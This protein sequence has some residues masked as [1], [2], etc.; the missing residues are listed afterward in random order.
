MKVA[1]KKPV[2]SWELANPAK[3]QEVGEPALL[4]YSC[5][6]TLSKQMMAV[7]SQVV[8]KHM[9]NGKIMGGPDLVVAVLPEANTDLY[10]AI[11][12]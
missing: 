2:V 7:G 3:V 8:Q 11:K 12:Q 1:E 9:V 6:L 5:G 10:H 4:V